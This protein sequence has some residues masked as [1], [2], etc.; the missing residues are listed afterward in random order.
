MY[1]SKV[2]TLAVTVFTIAI[3]TLAAPSVPRVGAAAI[4]QSAASN[5]TSTTTT[6]PQS[7]RSIKAAKTM[8][9]KHVSRRS[10]FHPDMVMA[11][12]NTGPLATATQ[13]FNAASAMNDDRDAIHQL[14]A[15]LQSNRNLG[16]SD[17]FQK[18][19]SEKL[20]QWQLHANT[21]P[22][23][24]NIHQSLSYFGRDKGLS[25]LNESNEFE[26]T[27]KNAVNSI[28][29]SMSDVNLMVYQVPALGP[30][31]GP[32]VYQIKCILDDMINGTENTVD[33]IMNKMGLGKNLDLCLL[34]SNMSEFC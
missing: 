20:N 27:L 11:R 23:L 10:P 26:V 18:E 3:A 21:I 14:L 30:I 2:V 5:S 34:M 29:Y 19:V 15:S 32:I 31:L 17:A 1:S 22:T 33:A 4:P 25:N 12:S 8:G 16:K 9:R 28:K 24:T 6:T 7:H 13:L